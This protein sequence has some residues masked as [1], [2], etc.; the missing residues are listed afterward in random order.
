MNLAPLV[1]ALLF[2]TA[3]D[4]GKTETPR[5]PNP[6]APSLPLLSDEEETKLDKVIDRFIQYDT[7][8][9]KG[10]EAKQALS[11]FQKL[12]PAAIPALLRGL[13]KAAELNN[14]CPA[15][16]I[17]KKLQRMLNRSN[18]VQLLEYARET[19]GTGTV[20]PRHQGFLRELRVSCTLR[21]RA[22][23]D[24]GQAN[25][26]DANTRELRRSEP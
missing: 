14:S 9:L 7:G 12:G 18:D 19:I 4:S 24:S 1:L 8:K 20:A 5:K 16:V 11:D 13:N 26:P 10:A 21:K 15:V 3:D 6:V 17:G 23:I 22:V 25:E 2:L